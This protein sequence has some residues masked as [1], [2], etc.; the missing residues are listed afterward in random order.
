METKKTV[1]IVTDE[2]GSSR[3]IA[4]QIA[5]VLED[6][7]RV[8]SLTAPNFKGNDVLPA[9]VIF[10]GCASPNPPAFAYLEEMFRHINLA[11]KSCGVFSDSGKTVQYL[12]NMVH[13]SE[14]NLA[15]PFTGS[16]GPELHKWIKGI[17]S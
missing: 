7:C 13:D 1:V 16:G 5:A 12:K 10:L 15:K 9:D 4:E 6:S 2:A 3:N 14:L 11:G 17:V 8:I